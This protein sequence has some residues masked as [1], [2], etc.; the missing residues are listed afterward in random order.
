MYT[1]TL[2]WILNTLINVRYVNACSV[3]LNITDIWDG[4]A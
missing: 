1:Y 4:L 2:I 3:Q